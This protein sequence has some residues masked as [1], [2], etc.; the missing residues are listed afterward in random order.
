[1]LILGFSRVSPGLTLAASNFVYH[2]AQLSDSYVEIGISRKH[3]SKPDTLLPDTTIIT[4]TSKILQGSNWVEFSKDTL[5]HPIHYQATDSL[6]YQIANKKG[7]LYG[8]AKVTYGDITLE[9]AVIEFDWDKNTVTAYGA[10]DSVGKMAGLPKFAEGDQS[11]VAKKLAYNFKSKKGKIYEMFTEEGEGFIHAGEAKKDEDDNLYAE[12][13]R[14]TTC[15]LDH[16]HFWIEA[17]PLKIV[18]NKI[19]VCGPTNLVVDGVRTPLFLPFALFPIQK[20]QRSGII[21]PEYGESAQ[22]GFGLT[23]GGYYF[24]LNDYMDLALRGDIYTGGSWRLNLSSNFAKRYKYNGN[25]NVSYSKL[26]RGDEL[27]NTLQLNKDFSIGGSFS[28]NPKAWPNNTL[29]ASLNIASRNNASLNNYDYDKHLE[30]SLNSSVNYSHNFKNRLFNFSMALRHFQ[31]TTNGTLSLTLPEA[32]FGMSRITPFKSK[33]STTRA[34]WYENIGFSYTLRAQNKLNTYDSLLF[35]PGTLQDF[36]L[37]AQHQIP[38][39]G[40]F[41]ILKYINVS[42]SFNYTE[43]WYT[44]HYEKR[45]DPTS[46]GDTNPQYVFTDTVGG[47]GASRYFNTGIGFSTRLYGR[48][49]FK[50]KIKAIRH[51]M[52]PSIGFSYRPDFGGSGWGYYKTVQTD[53]DGSEQKYYIYPTDLYGSVP[54]G[55]SGSINFALGNNL[56]M[57]VFS[58]KDTVDHTKKIK[59]FDALNLNTS[60]NLAADSFNLSNIGINGRTS[61]LDRFNINFRAQFDP[62]AVNEVGRRIDTYAWTADR[63]LARLTYASISVG[64]SFNSRGNRLTQKPSEKREEEEMYYAF[65]RFDVNYK[66]DWRRVTGANVDSFAVTQ[67][68]DLNMDLQL[69]PKWSISASTGYDFVAKEI[70][71]TT[72]NIHRDLHCWEM[73]FGWVPIGRVRNYNFG[74]NVKS[75]ILK[76]LKIEK[77]S[78]PQDHIF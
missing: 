11:F 52:T 58:R 53:P 70:T 37:G 48:A 46:I 13:A 61:V 36:R 69:G 72:I 42:P 71:Y 5:D 66:L 31:N 23:N 73:H 44:E 1:M 4:D 3:F 60:Y 24:A 47:F 6:K 14:Y 21:F 38:I 62:Y 19:L 20:G 7:V 40:S 30:N 59:I 9:A 16:P 50:G 56:E 26:R 78:S 25:L 32:T 76:D 54:T 55:K 28:L 15:D 27:L 64:T 18:P 45:Y 33:I 34:K 35:K 41:S 77:K 43:N 67:S 68:L 39:S 51:V 29:G 74:I 2:P 65:R 22:L 10:K 57:K 75:N 12:K 8:D 49:N 17:T 63:Q